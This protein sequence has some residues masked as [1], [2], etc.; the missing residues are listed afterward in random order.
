MLSAEQLQERTTGIGSSEIGA[1]AGVSPHATPMEVYCLKVGL[2]ERAPTT[3][4]QFAGQHLERAIASMYAE[5][6]NARIVLPSTVWPRS[7]NGTLRHS[8]EPW[9]IATPD[10]V[11]IEDGA[12]ARLVEIKNVGGYNAREWGDD[13][14]RD[15]PAHYLAQV[16]W[17]MGVAGI[18]RCDLV[19][20]IGGQD[21]RVFPIAFDAEL[22]ALLHGAGR[23]F[24]FEHVI[25]QVAPDIDASEG[26]KRYLNARYP[27]NTRPLLTAPE[28]ADRWARQFAEADALLSSA[29]T[30]RDEARN[31]LCD[32]IGDADGIE[33]PAWRATWKAAKSGGTDW[34]A[35]AMQL[36]ATPAQIA[37]FTRP[38]PR[39]FHFTQMETDR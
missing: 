19:A 7:V 5:R 1:I 17:Q 36:G 34:K 2:A 28:T 38:G 31:A 15:V 25:P 32:Y 24:W 33:A 16:T 3:A 20:L 26:T 29:E 18:T 9:M 4:Q 8:A 23:R 21:L 14:S 22:F 27:R 39:K 12:P 35:L 6:E 37:E 11:R 13:G 30:L 10:V